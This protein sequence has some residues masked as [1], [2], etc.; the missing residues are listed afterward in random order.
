MQAGATH[1]SNN[2][3][4]QVSMLWKAPLAGESASSITFWYVEIYSVQFWV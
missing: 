1:T 3:K 2:G 4:T